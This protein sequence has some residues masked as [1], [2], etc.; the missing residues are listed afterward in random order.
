MTRTRMRIATALALGLLALRSRSWA[1]EHEPREPRNTTTAPATS[2]PDNSKY[3]FYIA[4]TD[5]DNACEIMLKQE[6]VAPFWISSGKELSIQWRHPRIV[7]RIGQ[8]NSTAN[9]PFVPGSRTTLE[10]D[11]HYT[12]S[13]R[14]R[15][16]YL[17]G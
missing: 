4:N 2:G 6:G 10:A 11:K 13:C 8:K 17:K 7:V 5:T 15:T 3:V 9:G 12:I 16:L 1:I 14:D